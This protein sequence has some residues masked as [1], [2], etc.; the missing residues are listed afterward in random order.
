MYAILLAVQVGG[1]GESPHFVNGLSPTLYV[2]RQTYLPVAEYD[3]ADMSTRYFDTFEFLPDTAANR[4]AV[5]LSAP[6][7]AK[8]VVHPVGVYPPGDSK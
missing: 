3:P 1:L 5:E 6:A 7:N 8:V 2:D 4:K